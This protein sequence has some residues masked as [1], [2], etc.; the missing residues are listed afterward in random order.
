VLEFRW[1]CTRRA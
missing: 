1:Y